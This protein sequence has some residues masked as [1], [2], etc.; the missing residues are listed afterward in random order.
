[1]KYSIPQTLGV[2]HHQAAAHTSNTDTEPTNN[3]SHLTNTRGIPT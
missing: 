1:M 2:L 3:S